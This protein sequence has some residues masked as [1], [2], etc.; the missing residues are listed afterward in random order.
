MLVNQ[1]I[2]LISVPGKTLCF[3]GHRPQSINPQNVAAIKD[4]LTKAMAKA[5]QNGF[6][7]FIF[8]GALGTDQWAQYR[9]EK[10]KHTLPGIYSVLAMP[11]PSQDLKWSTQSK[12]FFAM[13]KSCADMIVYVSDD[14]YTARKMHLRSEWM[15]D[16]SDVVVAV[17]KTGHWHGG[18][19]NCVEYARKLGKP[20]YHIEPDTLKEEWI[21]PNTQKIDKFKGE[22]GWLSNFHTR[23]QKVPGYGVF[24]SNEH[25]YQM[26]KTHDQ[27]WRKKIRY[28]DT[29]GQ[30]KRLGREAPIRQDWDQVKLGIMY[31]GL[32]SKFALP[33]LRAKLLETFPFEL[34]EGNT[35]GDTY[36]GVCNGKGENALG[37]LLMELRKNL[38]VAAR[39]G[40]PR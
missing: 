32:R 20:I 12:N 34:V 31:E 38:L 14:P 15:V 25:W 13:L 3:T 35:W 9:A 28:S 7:K 5:Y 16:H 21:L 22:Y 19:F 8:G 30:A 23:D 18:T 4:I 40:G 26:Q 39:N 33:D 29:P 17:W 2:N 11:F 24:K 1:V 10:L 6:R 36:W 37:K 27:E